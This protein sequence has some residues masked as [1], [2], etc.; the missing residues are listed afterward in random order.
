MLLETFYFCTGS[1]SGRACPSVQR[2]C[3]I[4]FS[5]RFFHSLR[6][7]GS[8]FFWA[9]ERGKNRRRNSFDSLR[10]SMEENSS[11][12]DAALL[13]AMQFGS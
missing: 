12:Q 9:G 4:N 5:N 13:A 6:E 7:I 8:I 2:I 10:T 3:P 1:G 11:R